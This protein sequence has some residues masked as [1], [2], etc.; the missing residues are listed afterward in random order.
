MASEISEFDWSGRAPSKLRLPALAVTAILSV[1]AL[2]ASAAPAARAATVAGTLDT[3][4]NSGSG[5]TQQVNSIAV[6]SDGKIVI[7]GDFTAVNGVARNRIAR[8]NTDGSLDSSFAPSSGANDDVDSVAVQSDGKIL[9]GGDFTTV[10]GA[11]RNYITRLNTDG[12]LDTSF[13]AGTGASDRVYSLAVRPDGRILMT[14]IFTTVNGTTR[15]RV[16]LLNSDGSVNTGFNV[17]TGPMSGATG[18]GP[19][20]IAVQSDNKAIIVGWFTTVAGVTRNR[21]ARLDAVGGVDT[22]FNPGTGPNSDVYDADV[23][24]DGKILIA[25]WFATVGAVSRDGVARLNSDGSLDPTFDPGTGVDGRDGY[26]VALQSDGKVLLGGSFTTFNGADRTRIVR[27]DANGSVDTSFAPGTGANGV[28]DAIAVQADG[29]IL[30]GGGFAIFNGVTVNYIARLI[31]TSVPDPTPAVSQTPAGD[32]VKAGGSR[33]PRRGAKKLMKAHC[34]TDA[35]QRVGV[36][37][38]K[39]SRRAG[40]VLRCRVSKKR[41][42]ATIATGYSDGSRMCAKG[43]LEITARGRRSRLTVTWSAPATGSFAA[44]SHG[45]AY[46]S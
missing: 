9:I 30:I 34:A 5:A 22:S 35:G 14:G 45:K 26:E 39:H 40:Y 1:V 6:Q 23:Q 3:S 29:K 46:R 27:L 19:Y 36:S 41:T 43:E 31:G 13:N 24:P 28:V 12:S 21:V 37:V 20:D 44:Y 4:F 8:L 10:N 18:V 2:L 38:T 11:S 15:N 33:I 7:G 16:A 42:K 32:C 25:G 17:G